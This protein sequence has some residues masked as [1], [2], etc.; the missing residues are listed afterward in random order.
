MFKAGVSNSNGIGG[1]MRPEKGKIYL[2]SNKI[3]SN[4]VLTNDG[5]HQKMDGGHQKMFAL[6]VIRYDR[7]NYP[8]ILSFGIKNLSLFC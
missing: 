3:Q 6:T 8:H 7:E 5:D 2:I 4:S 1:H